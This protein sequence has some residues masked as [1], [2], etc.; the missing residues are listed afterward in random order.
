MNK[1]GIHTEFYENGQKDFEGTFKDG[2]IIFNKC[3]NEDGNE[4]E[5]D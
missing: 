5:C 2:E 4:K 1:N 3:W